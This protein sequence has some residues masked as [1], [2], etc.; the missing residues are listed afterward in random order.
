MIS[1]NAL[2]QTSTVT[3]WLKKSRSPQVLHSFDQACDL[4]NENRD[5]LSI[6]TPEIGNGPFN[7]VVDRVVV[8]DPINL[9]SEVSISPDR[10]TVGDLAVNI[11][12]AELW[13][14]RPNWEVLHS[15]REY[16]VYLTAELPKSFN[17]PALPNSLLESFSAAFARA[18]VSSA[19]T[20][21]SRLAGLG[22]GLTP[23]GDDFIMGGLY[24]VWIYHPL[25]VAARFARKIAETAVPLTTSLSGAWLKSA[26]R[27]E[28]GVV[29]HEFLNALM[30]E[31]TDLYQIQEK[32]GRILQV[33]ETSGGDAMA[34]FVGT[35]SAST[36]IPS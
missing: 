36:K 20:I 27:G 5:V 28:A 11:T 1:I 2:S 10:L 6:V 31:Q 32:M 34:G 22:Q 29:W 24:A 15:K 13:S 18:D 3:D 12:S 8:S 19:L 14:A 33:G 25:N 30:K 7:L 21:T 4:V 23:A 17:K 9:Q 35:L 26:G 16:I